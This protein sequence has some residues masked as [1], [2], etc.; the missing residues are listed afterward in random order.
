MYHYRHILSGN[1]RNNLS[2]I[3]IYRYR[4]L[5]ASHYFTRNSVDW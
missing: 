5:T 1:V 3:L 4:L 2:V